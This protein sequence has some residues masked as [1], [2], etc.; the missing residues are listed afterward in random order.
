MPSSTCS[1][2]RAT[3]PPSSRGLRLDARLFDAPP[4]GRPHDKGRPPGVGRHLPSVAVRVAD[5]ATTWARVAVPRWYGEDTREI[6]IVSGTALW[7]HSGKPPVPIRW[8]LI[9]DPRGVFPTQAL[10]CTDQQATPE[11][12]VAWFVL[13]WQLE[14]TQLHYPHPMHQFQALDRAA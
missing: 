14:N 6:E 12:I 5:P 9:R 7:C 3:L 4:L 10:L 11:Q 2:R 8:V 13:R 1:P